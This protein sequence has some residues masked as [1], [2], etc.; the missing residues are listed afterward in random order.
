MDDV[1][2]EELKELLSLA[3]GVVCLSFGGMTDFD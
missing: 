1:V 3:G 2:K